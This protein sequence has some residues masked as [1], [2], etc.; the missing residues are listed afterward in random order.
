M[1]LPALP[2]LLILPMLTAPP[3]ADAV[4]TPP[5]PAEAMSEVWAATLVTPRRPAAAPARMLRRVFMAASFS[6]P[7]LSLGLSA[8]PAAQPG[9][10]G[11]CWFRPQKWPPQWD[12]AIG[13]VA[14]YIDGDERTTLTP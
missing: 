9:D 2:P 8:P 3:L 7:T 12:A 14:L 4:A 5:L 13:L 6:L 10:P 11:P 1:A